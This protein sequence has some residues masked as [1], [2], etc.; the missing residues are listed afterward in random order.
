MCRRSESNQLVAYRDVRQEPGERRKSYFDNDV[1]QMIV[2]GFI[3][4]NER[5]GQENAE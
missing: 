5:Q 3:Y 4:R 2:G 1:K